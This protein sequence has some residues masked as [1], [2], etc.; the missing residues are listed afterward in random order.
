MQRSSLRYRTRKVAFGGIVAAFSVIIMMCAGILQVAVF[1]APMMAG[2]ILLPLCDEFGTKHALTTYIA[3]SL[4]SAFLVPDIEAVALF[5]A[6]FG[7]YPI[8]RRHFER[9]EPKSIRKALKFALFNTSI[10]GAYLLI[11]N[12]F[13]LTALKEELF[14]IFGV[15]L[16]AAGNFL[17]YSYDKII[18]GLSYI[19]VNK[20]RNLIFTN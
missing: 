19:Y 17:F 20:F 15:V 7:Y 1:A 18:W 16:L 2:L 11:I 13:G 6:F 12:A 5:I 10:V 8:T 3:V 14:G 9:I 4:L